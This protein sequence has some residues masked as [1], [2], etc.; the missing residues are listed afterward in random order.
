MVVIFTFCSLY[1]IWAV[2]FLPMQDYSEHL[3]QVHL[4][5][6]RNNPAF[7]YKENFD[8]YSLLGPYKPFYAVTA[9][10][11]IFVPIEAAGKMSI[12]LYILAIVLLIIKLARRSD[13]DFVPW[14]LLLFF[15]FAFNQQYFL[16]NTGYLYSLPLLVFGLFDA[17]R[18]SEVPLSIWSFCK[19]L[20]WQAALFLTHPFTFLIYISLMSVMVLLS[21][22]KRTKFIRSFVI[23]APAVVIFILWSLA[24]GG[25]NSPGGKPEWVKPFYHNLIFYGYIFTGMQWFDGVDKFQTVLWAITACIVMY[26]LYTDREHIKTLS[27]NFFIFFAATIIAL[28]VL[29]FRWDPYTFINLRIVAV[30]YFFLAVLVGELRFKGLIKTVFVVLV[31]SVLLHLVAKQT[32]ISRETD[33]IVPV[34]EK[35]PS[36]CRILPLIFD[37]SATEFDRYFF[38]I[39][40]HD[41]D[42]YHILIGGGLNPYLPTNTMFPVRYKAGLNLPAP[43]LYSPDLFRWER[44]APAYNYIIVRSPP[45]GFV[46][47][48]MSK[49][50]LISES[51]KW[52]LFKGGLATA[53]N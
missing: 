31:A 4:L 32:R 7:D 40:R 27:R 46:S 29:P 39:H 43:Y 13:T 21:L 2:R 44:Y 35:M 41:Y 14:G 3:L 37:S 26:T 9:F 28:C 23:L 52:F 12:S 24:M 51:G 53:Q 6:E 22:Q 20:L 38:E 47:Y 19:S 42:Y 49:T 15:P 10:F 16:G 1:P 11:S 50:T 8:Y 48:M 36:N 25:N 30:S 33:E 45:P 5:R 18:A 34:I 17:E